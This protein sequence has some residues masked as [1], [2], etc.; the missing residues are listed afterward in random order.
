MEGR[1]C[2]WH[3]VGKSERCH[4]MS[5]IMN[6]CSLRTI[7]IFVSPASGTAEIL[8]IFVDSTD[9]KLKTMEYNFI[10]QLNLNKAE[11]KKSRLKFFKNVRPSEKFKGNSVFREDNWCKGYKQF[12]VYSK[13]K[14]S[15]PGI[16]LLDI[17]PSDIH[18]FP[19]GEKYRY[20]RIFTVISYDIKLKIPINKDLIK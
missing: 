5:Q 8:H 12:P 4:S 7:F 16:L 17:H 15:N 19:N 3:L 10:F 1:G 18:T 2:Y 20:I 9:Y 13:I 6:N 14:I 11:M